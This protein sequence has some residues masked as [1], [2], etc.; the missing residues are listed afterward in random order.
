MV[1][2]T[3]V[4]GDGRKRSGGE[5]IVNF[6]CQYQDSRMILLCVT[7]ARYLQQLAA[8]LPFNGQLQKQK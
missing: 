7:K 6:A 8:V 2:L 3:R 4:S 5:I 1:V